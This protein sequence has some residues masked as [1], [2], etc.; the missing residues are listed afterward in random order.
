MR[1]PLRVSRQSPARKLIAAGAIAILAGG[2]A[3]GLHHLPGASVAMGKLDDLLYDSFYRLRPVED[4]TDGPVVIVAADDKSLADLKRGIG[5]TSYGWPW[6]RQFWG[7]VPGYARKCGAKAVAFDMIF[8]EPSVFNGWSGDDGAFAAM[9]DGAKL[10]VIFGTEVSAAGV[11]DPFAPPVKKPILGAVNVSDSVVYRRYRPTVN[12]FPSLASRA[13]NAVG[14]TPPAAEFRLHYFGPH[15]DRKDHRTFRYV[16]ASN[17]FAAA[18]GQKNTGVDP[19]WFRNKI[20]LIGAIT[21][22]TF[23][24]KASPLSEE[25]PGVEVQATAITDMLSGR[26]V[27]RVGTLWATAA[28]FAAA[29]IAAMGVVF[30]RTASLKLL[31]AALTAAIV[32]GVAIV[33][34]H[35]RQITW[36]PLASPLAALLLATIGA[37]SWSYLVEGR[38]RRF[39]VKA[40][41][42]YLS[43]H[44]AANIDRDPDALKLGGT[45]RDMTVMFTD[46]QG[47]TDLSEKLDEHKLT[48]LL[49]YYL[50]EMSSLV[51]ANDG[52]LDKYIGDAIMS[53]WNAPL[54]QPDHAILA[55]RAALAME[56]REREIQPRLAELG[57][58]GLLTRIGINT[59]PMV[60]GNMGSSQKFNYSVLGDSVNLASRLEGANKFYGSR[61][62]IAQ[63]TAAQLN[64]QFLLRRLDVLRV[65]GKTMPM[66][67]FELMSESPGDANL[68]ARAAEYEAAFSDYQQQKWDLA[69]ERLEALVSRFGHDPPAA[70]L[71]RRLAALREEPPGPG[72]DGVYVAKGK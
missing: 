4:Q 16:S 21:V 43:P 48:G 44:V 71:V 14:A 54:Y 59:G 10:P 35:G 2:L 55:C 25:Y 33:L 27:R 1:F 5:K 46:I 20:V 22:G 3:A 41:G 39:V 64:G 15:Q 45:R 57:G 51:L 36:L 70:A 34:F 40:L 9:I 42:Q 61:I 68:R 32:I 65:K 19:A 31:A 8:S 13:A 72:W 6:P 52:T 56:K 11:P 26:N 18:M 28:A 50:D 37:F 7:L 63:P 53:F 24:V 29:L 67:V 38:Q 30:P 49:N 60:F 58:P 69:R 47:F 62:I 66:A 23:D 12:E 17:V